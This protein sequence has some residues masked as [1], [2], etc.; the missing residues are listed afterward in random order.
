MD[1]KEI[2]EN[3]T[4]NNYLTPCEKIDLYVKES[5]KEINDKTLTEIN[6][7]YGANS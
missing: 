1:N 5:I 2:I 3:L 7:L 4:V 6:K